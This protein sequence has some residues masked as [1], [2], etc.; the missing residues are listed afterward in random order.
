[1]TTG[2]DAADVVRR[3][4]PSLQQ[5]HAH[6]SQIVRAAGLEQAHR[7]RLPRRRQRLSLCDDRRLR[8]ATF[9]RQRAVESSGG[10]ARNRGHASHQLVVKRDPVRA[11]RVLARAA[12]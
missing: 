6:R 9:E 7:A 5:R 4:E 12:A 10:D 11:I 1:M 3:E 8:T 2:A